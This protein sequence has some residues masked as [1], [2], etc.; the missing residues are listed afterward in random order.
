MPQKSKLY[1]A[2]QLWF[3]CKFITTVNEGLTKISIVPTKHRRLE[4]LSERNTLESF[5]V[6][7][8]LKGHKNLEEKL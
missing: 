3:H 5:T 6:S 8:F 1:I 7:V 2:F 4:Y